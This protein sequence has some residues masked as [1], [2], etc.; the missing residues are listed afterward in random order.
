MSKDLRK[1]TIGKIE[2]FLVGRISKV[3]ATRWAVEVLTTRTFGTDE[4]VLED[5][6]TAL[7]GL[8]DEDER[9][10]MA[11]EDLLY[12]KNCL[13]EETSYVVSIEFPAK[14]VAEEAIEYESSEG[15]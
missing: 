2:D 13:L 3:E 5:A 12:F 11:R 8:H 1:E 14:Q 15:N 4:L 10:D 6:I 9:F 7:A